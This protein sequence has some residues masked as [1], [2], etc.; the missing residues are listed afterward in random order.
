MKDFPVDDVGQ[1]FKKASMDE[2]PYFLRL[3]A[4]SHLSA[5]AEAIAM[6]PNR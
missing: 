5:A 3:K 1:S 6:P 4:T 2:T